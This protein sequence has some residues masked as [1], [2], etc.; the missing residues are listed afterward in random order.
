MRFGPIASVTL[1]SA[2]SL[3]ALLGGDEPESMLTRV[4]LTVGSILYLLQILERLLGLV[5]TSLAVTG[6]TGLLRPRG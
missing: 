2:A 4:D 1:P 5:L 3:V 6:F